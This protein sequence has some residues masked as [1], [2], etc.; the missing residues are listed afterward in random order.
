M[1]RPSH[2]PPSRFGRTGSRPPVTGRLGILMAA[3]GRLMDGTTAY[4]DGFEPLLQSFTEPP[5]SE[6]AEPAGYAGSPPAGRNFSRIRYFSSP[7]SRTRQ[8]PDAPNRQGLY[9]R[10]LRTIPALTIHKG[11]MAVRTKRSAIIM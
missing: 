10:A 5:V 8:N 3:Q 11:N 4:I 2:Y 1:T 9:F 6:M 7:L